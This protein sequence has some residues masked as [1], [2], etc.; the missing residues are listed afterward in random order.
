[1][2]ATVVAMLSMTVVGLCIAL[3][4]DRSLRGPMLLGLA[5]LYGSGAIFVVMFLLA[6]L[7]IRWNLL[8][9]CVPLIAIVALALLRR[10]PAT[11]NRPPF[12][13]HWLDIPTLIAIIGFGLF[14]TAAPLWEWDFWA[15]WGLKAR[16]FLERGGID[17]RYLEDRWN[18]FAHPDYPLLV[19]LNYDFVG[20]LNGGWS[21]R[22]LGV[23]F[24]GWSVAVLAIVRALTAEE[25]PNCVAAAV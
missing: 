9:V 13:P 19:P 7:H 3:A 25:A 24:F 18:E 16:V 5:Y 1:M 22:W 20:L 23:L 15:I 11:V 17:W 14:A 6:I 8:T 4:I 2:T 12:K 10:Q 21:D